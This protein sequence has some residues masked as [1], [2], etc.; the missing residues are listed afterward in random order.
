[1]KRAARAG[2]LLAGGILAAAAAAPKKTPGKRL[3]GEPA[4]QVRQEFE[5]VC[6]DFR[7]GRNPF[8]GLAQA[9]DLKRRL[10]REPR[11]RGER[12]TLRGRLAQE[13]LRVGEPDESVRLLTEA[14]AIAE[15]EKLPDEVR[16]HVLRDLGLAELRRGEQKNCIGYHG[17]AACILPIGE[18]GVHREKEPALAA[19]RAFREYL[20]ER[21]DDLVARWLFDVAAMTAGQYPDG[22]PAAWRA[23]PK[24][25]FSPEQIGR[26]S[27]VAMAVGLDIMDPSGGAIVDDFDGDGLLDVVTTTI[28][29]CAPMHFFHNDGK[30]RFEERTARAGLDGE[31][32]GLN[33]IHAD[34]DNDGFPDLLVLR[35]G[36]FGS[37]GRT[38]LSLLHNN[39]NGTFTDV[40][41]EAGLAGKAY[42]TQTA[43]W[44]DY[45]NDG[46]LDLYVGSEVDNDGIAYP[47]RLFHN[48][49]DG[50]FTEV[51]EKAGVEN[52]RMAKGVAWGDYDGDGYPDLYVSNI[53][54]NRLYHNN[55]DGTF[56][57]VA[58][59]AG[60]IEPIGRSFAT[61]FF[62]YD[63]DGRPDLFVADYSAPVA[64]VVGVYFGRKGAGGHP[65]LYH[66]EGNGKFRDVSVETG[67]TDPLLPMG[68][69]FGDLDNDGYLDIYLGTG[70]PSFESLMPNRMYR[71]VGGKRFVDVTFSGGFGHLQKGHGIAFA[72][73]DNDGDQ[74]V[75]EQ[76]GGAYPGDAYPSV[77]Y[78]NPGNGNSWVTVK[79]VGTRSNRNAIGARIEV[80]VPAEDGKPRSIFRTVGSVSSFGGSPHRQEIGLAKA[81]TI[82]RIEVF[83]PASGLRQVFR[84]VAPNRF[85]EIREGEGKLRPLALPR[86]RLA[87]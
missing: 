26:F 75:F 6:K 31:W 67:L 9:E 74:D 87:R 54:L 34:Y 82:S 7:A 23:D 62:D 83:W 30:G 32:G 76:M 68:A 57:D 4:V 3:V 78:E 66:N 64:D 40:T 35:G 58:G 36:W 51:A 70:L 56:T 50:T 61:G 53:G 52:F 21:P 45:D 14:R 85:Y 72:D 86:L 77:L 65:R 29:P 2:F 80:V 84:G 81:R 49:G 37:D 1:M 18:A 63:N 17:P 12:V 41:R 43:A 46:F 59:E 60:V 20:T 79:L 55:R 24:A 22:V 38:R 8:Y 69:N 44:A 25:F 71:N 13:L 47:S 28:N 11:D 73:I 27:D 10:A 39:G 33:V 5:S 42:P 16:L 15:A 48:N 19:M